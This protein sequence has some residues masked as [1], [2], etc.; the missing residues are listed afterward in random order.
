M[1]SL[2]VKFDDRKRD[3]FIYAASNLGTLIGEDEL[4]QVAM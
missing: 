3:N 4:V 2:T 1:A